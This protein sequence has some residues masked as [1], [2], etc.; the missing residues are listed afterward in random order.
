M[1][2]PDPVL[3]VDLVA[4]LQE[5]LQ[6]GPA[7]RLPDIPVAA[8]HGGLGLDRVEQAGDLV[9]INPGVPD[10]QE[11]HRGIARHLGAVAA[12]SCTGCTARV[13]VIELLVARSNDETGRQ[14]LNIPLERSRER[15]I[16]VIDVE[17]QLPV[18]RRE[19]AEI[20]QVRV[21]ASLHPDICCRRVRQIPRH[22]RGR[23]AKVPKSRSGHAPIPDRHQL[24]PPGPGLLLQ[25]GNRV[26][27]V[28]RRFPIRMARARRQPALP[29]SP[30]PPLI[31]CE[32]LMRRGKDA[33]RHSAHQLST[34]PIVTADRQPATARRIGPRPTH[35]Y[36]EA[37][38][39][40]D[41]TV[42]AP[43]PTVAGTA[44]RPIRGFPRAPTGWTP[45][46]W[47][48]TEEVPGL[49]LASFG[50]I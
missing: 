1:S 7:A 12:D 6:A 13:A 10:L 32:Q 8:P 18:G 20:Q 19:H 49:I 27:P 48:D 35:R 23:A 40:P 43:T 28:S 22:R 50:T 24:R 44:P 29:A 3:P 42:T 2:R 36:P 9:D 14:P 47:A 17:D 33:W 4:H 41:T 38:S 34:P 5:G 45:P 30:T 31:R 26:R 11:A 37:S 21:T 25:N 46:T 39:A 16:E 15:L